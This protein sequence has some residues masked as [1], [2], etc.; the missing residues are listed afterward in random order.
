MNEKKLIL[1]LSVIF[2]VCVGGMAYLIA[3]MPQFS[4]D[5]AAPVPVKAS[6][7]VG[8]AFSLTDQNGTPVTEADYADRYKLMFFGFTHC[9]GICPGELQ[10][11]AQILDILHENGGKDAKIVPLFVTIDPER[12]DV[13]AM[14]DYVAL[15]DPRI[16]GLTGT[17]DQIESIKSAYKVY[18]SKVENPMMGE[19]NYMMDHSTFTYLMSPANELL[20][21]FDMKDKPADVAAEI[22][23]ALP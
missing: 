18:A 23:G 21:V 10:K 11:I 6:S 19:G 13:A 4:E 2:L 14:K 12:D 8:G 9:P 1:L 15:F 3:Q 5:A 16:I 22:D 20:L 7:T 17:K